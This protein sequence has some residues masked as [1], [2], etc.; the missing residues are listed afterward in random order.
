MVIIL[1]FLETNLNETFQYH[2]KF[3]KADFKKQKKA[4]CGFNACRRLLSLLIV[5]VINDTYSF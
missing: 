5:T 2:V 4:L 3:Q 1:T